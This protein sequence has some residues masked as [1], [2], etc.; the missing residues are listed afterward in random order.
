MAH[1]KRG[2][3][4]PVLVFAGSDPSGGAGIQ[5]DILALAATGC[6]ALPVVTTVTVQ[7]SCNVRALYPLTADQISAQARTV[8][9]DIPAAAVKIGLLGS[10]EAVVAVASV[11]REHP[12]LP[13]V[14]DPV[15]A[16]G[17]GH[18][19]SDDP[20]QQALS[21]HLLPLTTLLTPNSP[22]ARLLGA[23]AE[24]AVAARHLLAR[25]CRY[26]L[27]TGSHETGA[28]VCNTLYGADGEVLL[29]LT[30]PRLPAEY[31]GSGCTLA[32]AVAGYLAQGEDIRTAVR[33]AQRYT[34]ESLKNAYFLGRG[35]AL[36]DRLTV[37]DST[38]EA[39]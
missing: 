16:A 35:Q 14:L 3:P 5:A 15:L 27:I 37:M 22:E 21:E 17:G 1:E 29:T 25:G 36:P 19:L 2:V 30:W 8:L 11:L 28:A 7:D 24:L 23:D 20:L 18:P 38:S 6:H 10:V 34:W 32:A 31:H 4:P 13:V 33:K 26:V 9:A 12:H 39:G